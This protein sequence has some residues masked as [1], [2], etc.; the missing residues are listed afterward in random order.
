RRNR[1][2][3]GRNR[4]RGGERDLQGQ[5]TEQPFQGEP[6]PVKG[7]LDLRDE[8]YGF[9]RTGGYLAS[10][11]DTYVSISQVRRFNLRKGDY[12]EGAA[13][14]ATSNEKYPALLRIDTVSG[15]T[16][17]E[18]RLRPKFEDLTPL[19]PD[20]KLKLEIPGDSANMT[21]RIVDLV[22]PI[23]KG[24]RGMIVSPPKAGKTTVLK[25]IAHSIEANDPEV[26]LIVLL[27]DE[28]PEEATD[29]RRSVKRGEVVASTFDRP[30]DEHTQVAEL[31]LERAKRLV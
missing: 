24:Q 6:V 19:F 8:G 20:Q 12:V 7:L 28:R 15:M 4:E 26:H 13:R 21:A 17:D 5:G 11:G 3:R 9:L 2:R 18:A 23:G 25:Q 1:R 30:S 31:S 16:P 27:V 10:P 22:S 14:P 29:W